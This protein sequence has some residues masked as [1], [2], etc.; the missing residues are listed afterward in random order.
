MSAI[1]SIQPAAPGFGA[2][3]R[4]AVKFWEWRR[5]VYNLLLAVVVIAWL[6][7]TWPHFRPAFTL[8]NAGRLFILA[9]LANVCYSAAY[10]ADVVLQGISA[11]VARQRLRSA[12]WILGTVFAIVF[13]NYWIADEIYPFV[14]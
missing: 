5:V 6:A 13:T 1:E 7:G 10:F 3:F 11:G 4:D 8:A 9:F 2:N 12:V 14:R